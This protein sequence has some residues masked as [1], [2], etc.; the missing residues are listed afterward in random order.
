MII[1]STIYRCTDMGLSGTNVI[2]KLSIQK[3]NLIGTYTASRDITIVLT[4]AEADQFEIG[5]E[6]T[7]DFPIY[8]PVIP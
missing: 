5:M 8:P 4:Q 1:S 3:D 6:Y 2:V 7:I